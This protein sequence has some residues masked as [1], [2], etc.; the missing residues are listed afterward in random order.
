M[1]ELIVQLGAAA[2]SVGLA[3]FLTRAA[4]AL[5]LRLTFGRG[6]M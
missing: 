6:P 1:I 2:T 4:L 5:C 3:L